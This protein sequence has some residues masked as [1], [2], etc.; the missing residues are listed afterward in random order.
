[1][2]RYSYRNKQRKKVHRSECTFTNARHA[3]DVYAENVLSAGPGMACLPATC[4]ARHSAFWT[5]EG[6]RVMSGS[7]TRYCCGDPTVLS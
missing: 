5:V 3:D 1:M 2:I 7:I 4:H 6:Y